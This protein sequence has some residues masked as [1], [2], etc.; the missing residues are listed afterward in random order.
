M[1]QILIPSGV[2]PGSTVELTGETYHYLANVRRVKE[3][4]VL[5]GKAPDNRE[6]RL[7]VR[8]IK[9]QSILFD[10]QPLKDPSQGNSGPEIQLFPFLLKGKKLEQVIRQTTEAGVAVI[11]PVQGKFCI[12]RIE[13]NK[14]KKNKL[15]RWRKIS[16]EAVQQSGSSRIPEI[17]EPLPFSQ[18]RE[19]FKGDTLVLFFHQDPLEK[20]SLHSYLSES[21]QKTALI[22][23]PEGGFAPE[24]V[25]QM[26]QWGFR[27]AYLGDSVLRAETASL[28]AVA[29]V[30][31]IVQERESWKI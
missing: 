3:G 9:E 13:N 25:E 24:E 29:A 8:E 14:D 20:E 1:K 18:L 31:T 10:S 19:Q 15:I 4:D 27:A 16:Q 21:P 7:T 23:G 22:I 5:K 26:L 17:R 30:K 28:Y 11:Q 2:E 6:Y 12:S